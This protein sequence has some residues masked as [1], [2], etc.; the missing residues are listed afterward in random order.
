[1]LNL[2][3][4]DRIAYI[5]A[6]TDASEELCEKFFELDSRIRDDWDA[7]TVVISRGKKAQERF[8]ELMEADFGPDWSITKSAQPLARARMET[9]LR[10][11]YGDDYHPSLLNR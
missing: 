4:C 1:M 3:D 5:L 9:A 6:E 11:V 7:Y 10:E 2:K 8:R